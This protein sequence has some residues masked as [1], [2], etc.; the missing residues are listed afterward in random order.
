[1][2]AIDGPRGRLMTAIDGPRGGRLMTAFATQ[3]VRD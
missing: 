2:T 3:E 1:M